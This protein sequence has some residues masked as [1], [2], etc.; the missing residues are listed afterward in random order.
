LYQWMAM[1]ASKLHA[2]NRGVIIFDNMWF[3]D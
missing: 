3:L 1:A 2:P